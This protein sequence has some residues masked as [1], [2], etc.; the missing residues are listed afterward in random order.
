M[1]L[2]EGHGPHNSQI[3]DHPA[4]T[5]VR[6]R[7]RKPRA[8]KTLYQRL[9]GRIDRSAGPNACHPINIKPNVGNGY[10]TITYK[11]KTVPVAK[12]LWI[13]KHGEGSIKPGNCICHSCGN[14]LCGNEGHH[15][16][17]TRK[18]NSNDASDHG[19]LGKRKLNKAS[20]RAIFI[21][22]HKGG[23]KQSVLSAKYGVT[24]EHI[25]HIAKRRSWAK[26]TA[27]LVHLTIK[28][29][30]KGKAVRTSNLIEVRV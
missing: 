1:T 11:G 20:A 2:F 5:P 17:G 23:T 15:Y 19:S 12:A 27:D 24:P 16:E 14:K 25:R 7:A 22:Y 21:A 26:A 10:P 3:A 6:T 13:E 29:P 30:A 8:T 28:K 18:Q 9:E 4:I